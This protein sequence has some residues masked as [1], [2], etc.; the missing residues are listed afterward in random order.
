MKAGYDAVE[1]SVTSESSNECL[2]VA[3]LLARKLV[4]HSVIAMGDDF[5]PLRFSWGSAATLRFWRIVDSCSSLRSAGWAGEAGAM[6]IAAEA[7]GLGISNNDHF[8]QRSLGDR[9]GLESSSDLDNGLMLPVAGCS[10]LLDTVVARTAKTDVDEKVFR[11]LMSAE[12]ALCSGGGGCVTSFL[13]E[14]L[15]SAVIASSEFRSILLAAVRRSVRL[16]SVVEYDGDDANQKG[17]IEVS[18]NCRECPSSSSF[19]TNYIITYAG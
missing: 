2:I 1:K 5:D 3:I 4:L 7:L 13:R 17:D 6:A 8:Q 12:V 9:S 11:L 10:K 18:G 14:S 15:Q 19:Y 16:L